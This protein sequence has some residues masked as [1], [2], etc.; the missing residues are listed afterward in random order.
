MMLI[1]T[2]IIGVCATILLGY[3]AYILMEGGA[4]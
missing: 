2:C 4:Y 1:I 3:Y